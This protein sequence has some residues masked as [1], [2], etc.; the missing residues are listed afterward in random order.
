MEDKDQLKEILANI[1]HINKPIDLE[2]S[3][4][5]SIRKEEL[6]TLKIANY[7]KKGIYG[8]FISFV[9]VIVLI[10]MYSFSKSFETLDNLVLTA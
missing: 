3:I 7:R 2:A 6:T 9:L 8:L 1:N 4:M 10:C 5:Q